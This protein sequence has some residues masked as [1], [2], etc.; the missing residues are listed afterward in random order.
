VR[1]QS[2]DGAFLQFDVRAPDEQPDQL[3][4]HRFVP[5]EGDRRA[6]VDVGKLVEHALRVAICFERLERLRFRPA[7]LFLKDLRRSPGACERAREHGRWRIDQ[8]GKAARGLPVCDLALEREW[9]VG[10]VRPSDRVLL[11]SD[12]VPND[13]YVQ[14]PPHQA[15]FTIVI[16]ALGV[17]SSEARTASDV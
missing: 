4:Q 8:V 2:R 14:S 6:A 12:R 10:V 3:A 13:K 5:D 1:V 17:A 15:P 9:A 16:G 7:C 11:F